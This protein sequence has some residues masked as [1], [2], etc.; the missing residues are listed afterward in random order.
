[1]AS[2][3]LSQAEANNRV[4]ALMREC[5]SLTLEKV[6]LQVALQ[7]ERGKERE[8]VVAYLRSESA[9][10]AGFRD[11]AKA[12]ALSLAADVIEHGD[13]WGVEPFPTTESSGTPVE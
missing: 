9:W 12:C 10:Q 4:D 11:A 5:A 13:H 6:N 1:M 7:A 8:A 3:R 2:D